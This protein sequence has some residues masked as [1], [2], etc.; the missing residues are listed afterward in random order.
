MNVKSNKKTPCK[1]QGAIFENKLF[2]VL[3]LL[4]V[5]CDINE[6]RNEEQ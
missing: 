1:K 5:D 6:M 2:F 3:N 4:V